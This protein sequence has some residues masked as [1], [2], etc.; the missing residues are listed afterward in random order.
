M[1][2]PRTRLEGSLRPQGRSLAPFLNGDVL[3]TRPVFAET[4]GLGG[5]FPSPHKPNVHAVREGDFKLIYNSTTGLR[6]LF[7][8][9]VDPEESCNV[10]DGGEVECNLWESLK[11]VAESVVSG[12]AS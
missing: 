9:S 8:L 1:T 2:P 11:N 5:P 6:E 4:G 10:S 12:E 7:N 3:P